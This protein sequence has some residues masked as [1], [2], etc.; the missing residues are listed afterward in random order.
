MGKDQTYYLSSI[1]EAQLKRVS[2]FYRN[3][4]ALMRVDGPSPRGDHETLGP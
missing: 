3:C 1:S 4:M 2:L